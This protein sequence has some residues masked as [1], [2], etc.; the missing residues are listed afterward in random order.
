MLPAKQFFY[1]PI[2]FLSGTMP[3][4]VLIIK[5]FPTLCTPVT[6]AYLSAFQALPLHIF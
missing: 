3:L 2:L 6:K 4:P 5:D 1:T